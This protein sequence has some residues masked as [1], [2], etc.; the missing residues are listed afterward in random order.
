MQKYHS[1]VWD[2]TFSGGPHGCYWIRHG[3]FRYNYHNGT[4]CTLRRNCVCTGNSTES[5]CRPDQFHCVNRGVARNG[6][7]CIP[8][9]WLC[10]N[11]N[12]CGDWSD[13][14]HCAHRT[15]PRPWRPTRASTH[16]PLRPTGPPNNISESDSC[17]TVINHQPSSHHFQLRG[18]YVLTG[19]VNTRSYWVKKDGQRAIWYIPEKH[20]WFVGNI[21]DLGRDMSYLHSVGDL[22][23]R[24]PTDERMS[25]KYWSGY[26]WTA[27]TDVRL[28]CQ[29]AHED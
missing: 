29:G 11:D 12:D 27:T 18:E 10:D 20:D 19:H 8:R 25:W 7:K 5:E 4:D 3:Q 13:E 17:C 21:G 14:Q 1:R 2:T 6:R 22:R 26:A 23:A 16:R 9:N 28:T 24:C 15:T